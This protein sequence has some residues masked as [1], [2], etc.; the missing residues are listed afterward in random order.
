MRSLRRAPT[1]DSFTN[2]V[3]SGGVTETAPMNDGEPLRRCAVVAGGIADLTRDPEL[4]ALIVFGRQAESVAQ[5]LR[6]GQS[7][8][9]D[10]RI[11]T[12]SWESEE[13]GKQYRTEIVA[14]RVQFGPKNAPGR[15]V[16]PEGHPDQRPRLNARL[17]A[18]Q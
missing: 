13:K 1:A 11:Q 7:A 16:A 12:R 18:P 5:Y 3:T 9:I 10:G 15:D 14:E 8:L 2:T 17:R 6:K 4:K